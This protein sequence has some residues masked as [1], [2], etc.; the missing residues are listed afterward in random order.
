MSAR[1]TAAAGRLLARGGTVGPLELLEEM[2]LLH[3]GHVKEWRHGHPAYQY[4]FEHIQCGAEKFGKVVTLFRQLAAAEGLVPVQAEYSRRSVNGVIPL[5]FTADGEP[6][7]EALFRAHFARPDL[8]AKQRAKVE[9]K[10]AKVEDLVVFVSV[11]DHT[12]CH[13]CGRGIMAGEYLLL[14]AQQPLCIECADM[15]HLVFLPAGDVAMTRRA[16]KHSP[17]SAVVLRFNRRRKHYDRQGLLVT[18]AALARAE[19][20]CIADADQRAARRQEAAVRRVVVDERFVARMS[21]ALRGLFPHCP[22]AEAEEIATHAAER[23]SGRVGRSAAG[24]QLDARAIT[25]AVIAHI[26]HVHTDYDR[27][28]M[29]GVDRMAARERIRKPLE[30]VEAKWRGEGAG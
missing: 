8:S 2:G 19:D 20:E 13:E 4:I 16:K 27:L 22:P 21:E 26:R 5:P 6:A 28:L 15:D 30:A 25:L 10:L 9:E 18:P 3:W 12:P 7:I 23:G 14:E 11:S 17:L 1:V 29:S 24:Q